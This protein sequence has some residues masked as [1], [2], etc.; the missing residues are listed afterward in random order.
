MPSRF[1]K[2]LVLALLLSTSLFIFPTKQIWQ[3][4]DTQTFLL[5][6]SSIA[7]HP[8]QQIFWAFL[9]IKATDILGATFLLGCFILYIFEGEGAERKKRIAELLYTLLWF[10]ISILLC[11]Q[12]LTPFCETHNLA[13]HSPTTMLHAQ[14][15]LSQVAPSCKI[16][17]SSYFCF[18]GDHAAIVFQWCT[19]LWYFAGWKRGLYGLLGSL[20]FLLPRLISGAHWLSDLL[21]GSLSIVL[22]TTTFALC[23][24]LMPLIMARLFSLLKY[25]EQGQVS[26]G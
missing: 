10:E 26:H 7:E 16:K 6:N 8:I 4:I 24:P 22:I 19:L 11:K 14:V 3:F 12:V 15:Y 2:L 9:N 21:V 5:L 17:D 1:Y 18:P 13:R 20:V 25:T 23:T